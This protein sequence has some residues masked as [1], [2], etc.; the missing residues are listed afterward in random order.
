[1]L[2]D[3]GLA[4]VKHLLPSLEEASADLIWGPMASQEDAVGHSFLQV[5]AA[6]G[7]QGAVGG[8]ALDE[9]LSEVG[10]DQGCTVE[11]PEFAGFFDEA[12]DG[13]EGDGQVCHG[14]KPLG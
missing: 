11:I 4:F 3:P 7:D 1:M 5:G 12:L 9:F 13:G 8:F 10:E 6:G 14:I 2:G